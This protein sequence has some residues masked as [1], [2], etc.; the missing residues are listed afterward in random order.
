[1][2]NTGISHSRHVKFSFKLNSAA[3]Q[4]IG[5]V[6]TIDGSL[7]GLAIFMLF[8]LLL[9]LI[10]SWLLLFSAAVFVSGESPCNP[11][12]DYIKA[13]ANPYVGHPNVIHDYFGPQF[14]SN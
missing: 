7:S 14:R 8:Y 10:A 6:D 5:G 12:N 9:Q 13:R 3:M 1:M 11:W 4:V 2:N